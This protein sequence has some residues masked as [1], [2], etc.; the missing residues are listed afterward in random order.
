MS[1]FLS[2]HRGSNDWRLFWYSCMTGSMSLTFHPHCCMT[3]CLC[4]LDFSSIQLYIWFSLCTWLFTH[5]AAWLVL[6]VYLTFHPHICMT[7]SLCVLDFSPVQLHEWFSL[8]TWLFT[9]TAA[10][11]VLFV[12]LTFLAHLAQLNEQDKSLAHLTWSFCGCTSGGSYIPCIY[13]HRWLRSLLCMCDV[14]KC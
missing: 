14:L 10:W 2:L 12:Y 8:C 7:D 6:S 13:P 3:S 5:T 4:V 9:C 1:F 11:L